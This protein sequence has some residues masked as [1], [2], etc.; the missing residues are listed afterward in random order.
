MRW[1][2]GR[3]DYRVDPGLYALGSP[4]DTSPVLVTA[5]YK[6]TFDV[7]R[8]SLPELS[9]WILVLDTAGINVWCAAGKGTFGTDELVSRITADQLGQV[10]SH[11]RVI[12][13]QL[14]A[15]GVAAREVRRRSGFSVVWGPARASDIPAFLD[16]GMKATPEMRQP[17]FTPHDRLV[18]A[19]V[20]LVGAL[21]SLGWGLLA[22]LVLGWI[23]APTWG[24]VDVALTALRIFAPMALGVLGGAVLTPLLLPWL[25]PR[26]FAAKGAIV[27]A[28][29]GIALVVATRP[30]ALGAVATL[31]L[32]IA[33][34][35][36]VA[37]NFTGSTPF[38][39][40]SGVE[41]EMRRWLPLQIGG[42]GLAAVSLLAGMVVR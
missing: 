29:I 40:L 41:R 26:M 37:M 15:T 21:P 32:A 4:D 38:T 27:G 31:L 11:R 13:P 25:P 24:Y 10:V 3:E 9:A 42:V 33:A 19:P 14:G 34:T 2:V 8:S 1:G 35:S 23:S 12:V 16:A 39:S 28:L 17:R 5:N 36:F 22:S 7:L 18:L 30:S 20:E 6:L